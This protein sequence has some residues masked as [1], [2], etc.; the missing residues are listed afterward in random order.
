M[1]AH[2]ERE[3]VRRILEQRI[4]ADVH[5]VEVDARQE[6]RQPERLLVGD[7]VDLVAAP[8]ERD[9]ELGRDARRSRRTS[10]SR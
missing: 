7:E 4:A 3:V 1:H 2:G 9:P 8:R 6:R 5:F 10:D